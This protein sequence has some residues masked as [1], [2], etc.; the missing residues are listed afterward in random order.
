MNTLF[1]ATC[2]ERSRS[3]LFNFVEGFAVLCLWRFYVSMASPFL[4]L[5]F[6]GLKIVALLHKKGTDLRQCLF[7]LLTC[8]LFSFLLLSQFFLLSF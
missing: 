5:P 8:H 1:L 3:S 4:A 6:E 2:A 7:H